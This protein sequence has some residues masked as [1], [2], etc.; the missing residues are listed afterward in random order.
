VF[1]VCFSLVDPISLSNVKAHWLPEL[2]KYIQNPRIILVGTKMDL[3]RDPALMARLAQEGRKPIEEMEGRSAAKEMK[4]SGFV[5]TYAMQ[6][7]GINEV[8]DLAVTTG[9]KRNKK[10]QCLLL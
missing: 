2:K 7:I 4:L 6:Q 5:E 10:K 3:R 8:F 1:L 9:L